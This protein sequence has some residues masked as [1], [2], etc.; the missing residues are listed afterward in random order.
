LIG[1]LKG[2]FADALTSVLAPSSTTDESNVGLPQAFGLSV[3]QQDGKV[4]MNTL[5]AV[6]Q[7]EFIREEGQL[8]MI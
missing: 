8:R 6:I 3:R 4:C 1:G 2:G 5:C 7:I